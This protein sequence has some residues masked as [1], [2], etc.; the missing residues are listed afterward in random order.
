[1]LEGSR[2]TGGFGAA[3]PYFGA[4]RPCIRKIVK[5]CSKREFIPVIRGKIPK[6]PGVY[7]DGRKGYGGLAVNG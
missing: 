7:T 3:E 1:M 4:G 2:E 5:N 6:K